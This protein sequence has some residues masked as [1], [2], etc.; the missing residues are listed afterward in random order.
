MATGVSSWGT[1]VVQSAWAK[2]VIYEAQLESHIMRFVGDSPNSIIQRKHEIQ[3]YSGD[4][5][6][7]HLYIELSNAPRTGSQ[8]MSG[9]EETTT[10]YADDV[11]LNRTRH[12]VQ[13]RNRLEPL[14]S[15]KN[16]LT[17]A[18]HLLKQY[19]SNLMN[20]YCIRWLEGDSSMSWPETASQPSTNR[21]MYGG[22]ATGSDD[23][24]SSDIAAGDWL[25]T[26]EL[27]R[28]YSSMVAC[29]PKF[30]P[31]NVDGM[32]VYVA[33][34]HPRH[35]YTLIT[36]ATW[37]A[38]QEYAMPRGKLNPIF[39]GALGMWSSI[40]LFRDENLMTNSSADEA[41][42]IFCGQQ[43][44]MMAMGNGPFADEEHDDYNDLHGICLDLCWGLKKSVFNSEDFSVMRMDCYAAAPAGVAH[45]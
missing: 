22:D 35:E 14:K 28:A 32:K 44:A 26:A 11:L 24:G 8:E 36:D 13:V 37:Q 17:I 16:H 10:S 2:D 45:S 18:R 1:S 19:F 3:K 39:T 5:V 15:N 42:A 31:M 9:N 20:D 34:I 21:I 43:A 27:T 6:Y 23:M 33:F 25:G 7:F 12:A 40:V 30:R 41:S 38:A 29:D 4:R